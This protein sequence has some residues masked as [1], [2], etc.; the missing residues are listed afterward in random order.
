[1]L[2]CE[3]D[4]RG[5]T[6]LEAR[7]YPQ[8]DYLRGALAEAQTV[9]ARDFLEQGLQGKALGQAIEAEQVVRLETYRRKQVH[10]KADGE[11]TATNSED[12]AK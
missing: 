5:R 9:S 11:Q 6:G 1:M 10:E 8:G 7:D 3:A 4:A 2:A 12:T